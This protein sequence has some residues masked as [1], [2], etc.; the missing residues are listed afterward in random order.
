M[1]SENVRVGMFTRMALVVLNGLARFME[2]L[3]LGIRAIAELMAYIGGDVP[4]EV[5]DVRVVDQR[6]GGRRRRGQR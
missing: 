5:I 2:T 4:G 6:S 1:K 3:A